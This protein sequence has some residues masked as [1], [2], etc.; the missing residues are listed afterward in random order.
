MYNIERKPL[1]AREKK[2]KISRQKELAPIKFIC[3]IPSMNANKLAAL[4]VLQNLEE[5]R[6][7][8]GYYKNLSIPPTPAGKEK[9]IFPYGAK[10]KP[11]P[12]SRFNPKMGSGEVVGFS[13]ENDFG[14]YEVKWENGKNI[15]IERE[16]DLTPA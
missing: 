9:Q 14:R 16:K 6:Q 12:Y 10:V 13:L 11:S 8:S 7:F 15:T 3:Y 1:F 2:K 5:N 4:S